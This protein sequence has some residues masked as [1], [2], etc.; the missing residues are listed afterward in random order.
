MGDPGI[1]CGPT[2]ADIELLRG[3]CVCITVLIQA[4][5]IDL[6]ANLTID[7]LQILCQGFPFREFIYRIDE[8]KIQLFSVL[9]TD[10]VAI[11]IHPAGAFQQFDSFVRVIG[12][13]IAILGGHIG[14]AVLIHSVCFQTI[15]VIEILCNGFLIR[16]IIQ[17]QTHIFILK[18]RIVLIERNKVGTHGSGDIHIILA[19][20]LELVQ[21]LHGN[22]THQVAADNIYLAAFQRQDT[23]LCICNHFEADP[24]K[25]RLFAPIVGIGNQRE[26][27]VLGVGF[28]H[29][30]PCTHRLR[31]HAGHTAVVLNRSGAQKPI[32]AWIRLLNQ[33]GVRSVGI[34]NGNRV[35]VNDL[36][37]VNGVGRKGTEATVVNPA[38]QIEF[39]SLRIEI[40][41]V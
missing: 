19:A 9:F 2:Q 15:S 3:R 1:G 11:G 31:K 8:F 4:S 5:Q 29:P 27:L 14:Y 39:N 12:I 32:G 17:C 18:R 16:S 13:S 35:L 20:A 38:L 34:G 6:H 7:G 26:F 10:T 30:R 24:V 23:G 37:I 28:Q 36:N 22:F 25:L 21:C 40:S 41:S 33:D